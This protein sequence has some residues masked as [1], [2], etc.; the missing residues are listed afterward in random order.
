LLQLN[1]NSK[2][3]GFHLYDEESNYNQQLPGDLIVK[4]RFRNAATK[5]DAVAR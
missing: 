4:I 2:A 5:Y 1:E 3:S